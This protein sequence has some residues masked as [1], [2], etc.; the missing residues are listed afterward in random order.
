MKTVTRAAFPSIFA[1]VATG[2][3]LLLGGSLVAQPGPAGKPTA[4]PQQ[5]LKL[6][7][8][9]IQIERTDPPEDLQVPE[10]FRISTYENVILQVEKTKKFGHVYRSGDRRAAD[11]PDLIILRMVPQAYKAGSQKQREVTTVSG[12]TSI[13]IRVTFSHRDGKVLLEK[14]L[15]GKVRFFGDNLRAT[16]DF[17]KKVADVVNESF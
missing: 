11:A 2:A 8:S 5:P 15:D 13:K 7:A 3:A 10:D 1:V 16:Y 6:T 17:A 4:A 14:D 12:G 9:A